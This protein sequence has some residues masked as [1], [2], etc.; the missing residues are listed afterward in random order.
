MKQKTGMAAAPVTR[1]ERDDLAEHAT[2]IMRF[3]ATLDPGWARKIEACRAERKVTDLQM[4]TGWI[5]KTLDGESHMQMPSHPF[6]AADFE[7]SR[8]V[9]LFSQCGRKFKPEF[10]GQKCCTDDCFNGYV[11]EQQAHGALEA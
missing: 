11:H 9:C 2:A 8:G 1:S 5:G 7:P 10:A 6:F 4:L 3:T